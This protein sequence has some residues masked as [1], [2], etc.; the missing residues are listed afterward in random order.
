MKILIRI[1]FFNSIERCL[2][3]QGLFE[4]E[5][6]VAS[7]LARLIDLTKSSG[8]CATLIANKGEPVAECTSETA[9][10]FL[11]HSAF[12]AVNRVSER[13]LQFIRENT[14]NNAVIKDAEP[15]IMPYLC[16]NLD[17]YLTN[18]PC[19]M[20]SMALLHSRIKRIF[21]LD[22]SQFDELQLGRQDCMPDSAFSRLEIHTKKG[23]NHHF[24]V[25]RVGLK[26]FKRAHEEG[27]WLVGRFRSRVKFGRLGSLCFCFSNFL[28]FSLIFAFA[29][30]R[31][32]RR[33]K[34]KG[35]KSS[36][37]LL[38]FWNQTNFIRLIK[39]KISECSDIQLKNWNLEKPFRLTRF[40]LEFKSFF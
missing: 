22:L 6:F 33:C 16:T 28:F 31:L 32:V 34:S 9:T 18:E 29:W 35:K 7:N 10:H 12:V 14:K 24:E 37:G 2:S 5:P 40:S 25:F 4:G 30:L 15:V 39:W 27:S 3:G 11:H 21:F 38:R 36:F 19:V 26:R 17:A 13:Q 23:L 1:F 8:L 20:C